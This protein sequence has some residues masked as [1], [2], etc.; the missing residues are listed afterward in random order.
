[1]HLCLIRILCQ[2]ASSPFVY[3]I[4]VMIELFPNPYRVVHE[5]E[6]WIAVCKSAGL[7]STG[8]NLRDPY[9]LQHILITDR[10]Q[11]LWAAHQLDADTS[12]VILF[13]PHKE[14]VALLKKSLE[15]PQTEKRYLALCQGLPDFD[16][17]VVTVPIGP[18]DSPRGWGVT[19]QGKSAKSLV[20]VLG[21][22]KDASLVQVTILTGRTHQIRV[23]MEHLG[24]PLIGEHWYSNP[25]CNRHDRQALHALECRLWWRQS[26]HLLVAEPL[27]D[28]VAC[29]QKLGLATPLEEKLKGLAQERIAGIERWVPDSNLSTS[30]SL[31]EKGV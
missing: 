31:A 7:P 21:R 5:T 27:E 25:P 20:R 28:F 10:K 13:T 30:P 4:V 9:C 17:H 11:H 24:H 15:S 8:L 3:G 26:L 6:R 12:G 18:L 19:E 29:S 16:E 14:E 1:M 2:P 22:G 23:H